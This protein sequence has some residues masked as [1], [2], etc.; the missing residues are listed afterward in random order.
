MKRA[1]FNAIFIFARTLHLT[2]HGAFH[3]LHLRKHTSD[4]KLRCTPAGGM[5]FLMKQQR[6]VMQQLES[7]LQG[8]GG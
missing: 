5:Y 6:N 3:R 2:V 1:A 4:L 8:W 7:R